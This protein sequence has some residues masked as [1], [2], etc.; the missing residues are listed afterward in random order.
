MA[1]LPVTPEDVEFFTTIINPQRQYTSSSINGAT[2]S[3]QLFARRSPI[4]KEP[5]PL[6]NFSASYSNDE[7]LENFRVELGLKAK[8][9]LPGSSFLGGLQTYFDKVNNQSISAK[10]QKKIEINRF[11]PTPQFTSNTIRKLNVKEILMPYYSSQ[12]PSA[13]WGYTNYNTLNFFTTTGIPTSSVLLYP[14]VENQTLPAHDGYVTGT[15]AISGAFSF[16]FRINPRYREDSIDADHFKAGTIFHLSSSYALSLITGSLKDENGLPKGFRLKLQL[17]H[18]ADISPSKSIPGVYPNDLIF[19]SDDNALSYNNWHRV[20]VRWGTN[21]VN[22]GTGSFNIDGVD[23]GKF[24][25]PSGTIMPKVYT[26]RS[27]PRVLCVGNYY[28]GNNSAASSQLLF[29]SDV[30]ADREGLEELTN[31]G[32][33]ID[34]PINYAF[35]HPLKAEVHELTIKRTY[36]SNSEIVNTSGSGLSTLDSN[37]AFYCPPFFTKNSPT[38]KYIGGHGGVLFTPFQEQDGTTDDPFNVGMAFSVAGHYIN[39]ENFAKD[40]ANDVFPRLHHLT[41][42]AIDYTTSAEPA[43]DILYKSSFVKKRNLTILPCDEGN[44]YPNYGLLSSEDRTKYVDFFGR[45]DLSTINLDNLVNADSLLISKTHEASGSQ[46]I[47]ELIGFSPEEP[48]LP[49]G[50][51]FSNYANTSGSVSGYPLT[52]FQRLK[53][54]SSDQVTFFDISNLF[55]GSKILPGT[56]T[57]K[58]TSLSGSNSRISITLKDDGIGNLY[59]ADALTPHNKLNCVGN[60]FYNEG[61]IVIKSPHLYFFG[62]NNYEMSFKGEQKLY[63]SKYEILAPQGYLN[64][65]SNPSFA[66]VKNEISASVDPWDIDTFVYISDVNFHDENLNVVAKAKLAQPVLKREGEKLLFKIAFDW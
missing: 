1:L 56:F 64:S 55:Y 47:K 27:D 25:I 18:S 54:P 58:D 59:R 65:S 53:D 21:L 9:L 23:V 44:F 35:N 31:T 15:Y 22:E 37:V 26:T 34:N 48:G 16:D 45:E 63:S 38:R 14:S 51:A 36:M 52:I 57:L 3:L 24:V 5:V 42:V 11:T 60:I 66:E 2:G 10:K 20:V 40:F 30:V 7:N 13:G 4:E 17:S 49:P 19:L 41:G 8:S 43:N 33:V 6:T 39:L 12:Y 62:K 28:E 32:G 29:F 61:V 46:F 50:P